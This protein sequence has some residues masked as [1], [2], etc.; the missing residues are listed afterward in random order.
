VRCIII[1]IF[2]NTGTHLR[3]KTRAAKSIFAGGSP[4]NPKRNNKQQRGGGGGR[5]E[6]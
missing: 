1:I 4:E 2:L 3:M 6:E 5:E